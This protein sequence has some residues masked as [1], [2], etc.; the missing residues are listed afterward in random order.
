M[1]FELNA[2][3][4]IPIWKTNS[5]RKLEDQKYNLKNYNYESEK[6]KLHN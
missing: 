2:R 3:I 5:K 4:Q 6:Q 1:S